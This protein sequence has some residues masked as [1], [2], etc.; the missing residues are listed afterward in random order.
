MVQP[1]FRSAP[2]YTVPA[3]VMAGV[4]LMWVFLAVWAVWGFVPVLLL[5]VLLTHFLDRMAARRGMPP[6]LAVARPRR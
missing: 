4:N 6:L 2:N 5:S 3:L 1:P